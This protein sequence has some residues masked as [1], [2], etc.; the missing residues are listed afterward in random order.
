MWSS[1]VSL[2][3][4]FLVKSDLKYP[5]TFNCSSPL[6]QRLSAMINQPPPPFFSGNYIINLIAYKL[7]NRRVLFR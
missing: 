5:L 3:V 6:F 2:I 4:I 7:S 1:T